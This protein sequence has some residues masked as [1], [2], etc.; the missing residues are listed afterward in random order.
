MN[1]L[2]PRTETQKPTTR[3]PELHLPALVA[4]AGAQASKRYFEFFTV[5]IRNRNTRENYF[6]TCRVFFDWCEERHLTLETIE[7]IHVA[8]YVESRS[9]SSDKNWHLGKLSLK[10]HVS[11]LRMMFSYFTEKGVLTYNPAREVKTEK[12]RRTVGATPAYEVEDVAK[13]FDFFSGQAR[14]TWALQRDAGDVPEEDMSELPPER[15]GHYMSVVELRDRALIGVMAFGFSRISAIVD[16]RVR[17]YLQQGRRAF[18]R[19]HGK[20]GVEVDIPVHHELAQFLDDYLRAAG[21]SG[22]KEGFLFRSAFKKT[23]LLTSNAMGRTDAWK[24]VQRR[25]ESAGIGGRIGYGCHSFRA[26][27]GTNFLANGGQLEICQL[28]MGHADSRTTKLYD[29]RSLRATLD[30][31]ERIRYGRK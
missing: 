3:D 5:T 28:L 4:A 13:L 18:I 9:T 23:G 12:V 1:D 6:R 17:D 30:D 31:I 29:R 20:G 8:A 7:P 15:E 24:M 10:Q 2:I 16:L 14:T 11:A 19:T 26:T 25:L 27:C 22:D 21:L